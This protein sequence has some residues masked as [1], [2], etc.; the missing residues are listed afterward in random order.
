MSLLGE[1]KSSFALM[2]NM[3]SDKSE[4]RVEEND[5]TELSNALADVQMSSNDALI[6]QGTFNNAMKSAED[7]DASQKGSIRLFASEMVIR[8]N[9]II[10]RLI[11]QS[12]ADKFLAKKLEKNF[13]SKLEDTNQGD[14][15]KDYIV[16]K[17]EATNGKV[18]A[19]PAG[20][21][22]NTPREIGGEERTRKGH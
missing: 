3:A 1:L 20:E 14:L 7:L 12:K 9:N 2:F 11:K 21:L 5:S 13:S 16:K 15:P 18:Q 4:Y 8:A 22:E 17:A 10:E 6:L 19:K